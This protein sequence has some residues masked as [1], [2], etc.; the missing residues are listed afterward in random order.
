MV[1]AR[2]ANMKRVSGVTGSVQLRAW[3]SALGQKRHWRLTGERPFRATSRLS[4]PYSI[5]LSALA[6]IAGG[7]VR[8]IAAAVLRLTMRLNFVG[9]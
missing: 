6:I 7:M 9:N 3:M 4:L 2:T 5:T 8:P 1:A